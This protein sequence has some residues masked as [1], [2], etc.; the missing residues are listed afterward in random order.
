MEKDLKTVISGSFRKHFKQIL[1]LKKAIES[2]GIKVLSPNG[3]S[4]LNPN[5]EFALLDSD[6]VQ[7]CRLL[8]DS[9]FAKIR[10]SS[11]LV[12]ANF[13][14]YIG[15]AA[16]MEFGYA[17]SY[18]LDILTLEKVVDPNLLPY[19]KQLDKVLPSISIFNKV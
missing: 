18:G 5:D 4:V 14:G 16:L 19:C 3:E 8:Q 6:P 1:V 17:V 2:L 9:V 13:D 7:D 12:L 15:R 10:S 11:F